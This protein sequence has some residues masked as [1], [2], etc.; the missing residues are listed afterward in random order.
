[1]FDNAGYI[2]INCYAHYN[3]QTSA[4]MAMAQAKARG[5]I[6]EDEAEEGQY[7]LHLIDALAKAHIISWTGIEDNPVVQFNH[8][9]ILTS[10]QRNLLSYH[11]AQAYL[12]KSAFG[13]VWFQYT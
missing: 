4:G 6:S 11:P 7:Q 10:F 3:A 12:D 13:S 2:K 1:M 5:C 8:A 9:V